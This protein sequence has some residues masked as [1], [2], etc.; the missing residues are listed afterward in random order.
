MAFTAWQDGVVEVLAAGAHQRPPVAG[1]V[2]DVDSLRRYQ[3][4]ETVAFHHR[5]GARRVVQHGVHD[6]LRR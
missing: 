4:V 2:V 5:R 6:I 3:A 1:C